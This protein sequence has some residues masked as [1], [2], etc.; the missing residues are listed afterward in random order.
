[1]FYN[2]FWNG[3][4]SLPKCGGDQAVAARLHYKCPSDRGYY[5][6]DTWW[7][8]GER[9]APATRWS[10]P[11]RQSPAHFATTNKWQGRINI[12]PP[13]WDSEGTLVTLSSSQCS[14]DG[15]SHEAAAHPTSLPRSHPLQVRAVNGT[16]R[17]FTVLF[18]LYRSLFPPCYCWKPAAAFTVQNHM[19]LC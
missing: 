14:E 10:A 16:S 12:A 13:A 17:N 7:R 3:F 8:P 9:P 2:I 6:G 19:T 1:M 11:A 4:V 18:T 15:R 5:P